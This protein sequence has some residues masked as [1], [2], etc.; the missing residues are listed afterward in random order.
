MALVLEAATV[1]LL[2]WQSGGNS[3]LG[4]YPGKSPVS[5]DFP[6]SHEESQLQVT[7][8]PLQRGRGNTF[9]EG[10][11]FELFAS[12][13]L[14]LHSTLIFVKSFAMCSKILKSESIPVSKA[15]KSEAR[16]QFSVMFENILF[17]L[18]DPSWETG[19]LRGPGLGVEGGGWR[20]I[21]QGGTH[22]RYR[23][24]QTGW[25]LLICILKGFRLCLPPDPLV[26]TS[27]N[28]AYL[29]VMSFDTML[30][31]PNKTLQPAVVTQIITVEHQVQQRRLL[32]PANIIVLVRSE[33]QNLSPVP[34]N[35]GMKSLHC[36]SSET[37]VS[38]SGFAG[39]EETPG[40]IHWSTAVL[41]PL[42]AHQF[43]SDIF[44]RCKK[45][46]T[47]SNWIFV[48]KL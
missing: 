25:I 6:P 47:Y 39:S 42:S 29:P 9:S 30:L 21:D 5:R 43:S 34:P 3:T 8:R 31:R 11:L 36:V 2:V 10:I 28:S 41:S 13:L 14:V 17:L 48:E 20:L 44:Y 27:E 1:R 40:N 24:H 19:G 22:N 18:L 45:I 33:Q 35:I 16:M 32:Q 12:S 23:N 26:L 15:A 37:N 38:Y 46:S 4:P 7:A